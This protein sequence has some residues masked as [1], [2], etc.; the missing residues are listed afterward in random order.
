MEELFARL[1]EAVTSRLQGPLKFRFLLQPL[2]ATI[3]AVRAG[4]A[5]G[6]NGR[7][8]FLWSMFSNPAERAY[9]LKDG[10]KDVSKVFI[11]AVVMDL[12]YQYVVLKHLYPLRALLVAAVLCIVPYTLIRGPV[13]RITRGRRGKVTPVE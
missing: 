1:Q 7:P 8:A 3:F 2:V 5:D 9:L 12:V 11:V 10:W 4:M 13:S 6:R